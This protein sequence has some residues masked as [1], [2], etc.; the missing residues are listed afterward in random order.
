MLPGWNGRL[1]RSPKTS[2]ACAFALAVL[3]APAAIAQGKMDCGKA[4]KGFWD[5]LERDKYDKISP[6]QLAEHARQYAAEGFNIIGGCCGVRPAHITA[7]A[8]ALK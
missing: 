5:K 6:E 8:A 7:I 2:R 3:A 1:I 4:Y